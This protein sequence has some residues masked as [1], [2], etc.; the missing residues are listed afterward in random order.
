MTSRK[1]SFP[2]ICVCPRAFIME[3]SHTTIV[4]SLASTFGEAKC[5]N[6]FRGEYNNKHF[7]FKYQVV[8][9]PNVHDVMAIML[10]LG[11]VK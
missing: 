4:M 6:V 7:F 5:G 10:M 9:D 3:G 11:N 8:G 2:T 1:L